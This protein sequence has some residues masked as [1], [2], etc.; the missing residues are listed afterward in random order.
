MSKTLGT[1]PNMMIARSM[2]NRSHYSKRSGKSREEVRKA[3]L[4]RINKEFK[5]KQ[6][7]ETE[8]RET[9]GFTDINKDVQLEITDKK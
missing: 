2:S 1:N 4:D 5:A 7:P 6:L 9:K 8:D 3:S